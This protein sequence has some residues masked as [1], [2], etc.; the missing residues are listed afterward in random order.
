MRPVVLEPR[1]RLR[2]LLGHCRTL[3]LARERPPK[4]RGS[5]R[6]PAII[7]VHHVRHEGEI[8]PRVHVRAPELEAEQE[9]GEAALHLDRDGAGVARHDCEGG[10]VLAALVV[11]VV[12]VVMEM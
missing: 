9:G 4:H 5:D 10:H 12:V 7:I 11:V 6:P 3:T 8:S 2:P 1:E